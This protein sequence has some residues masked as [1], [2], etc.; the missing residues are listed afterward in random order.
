MMNRMFSVLPLCAAVLLSACGGGGDGSGDVGNQVPNTSTPTTND[1]SPS[2]KVVVDGSGGKRVV[3]KSIATGSGGPIS[4]HQWVIERAIQDDA[5]PLPAL[6]NANCIVSERSFVNNTASSTCEVIAVIPKVAI[7]TTWKLSNRVSVPSGEKSASVIVTAQPS[8]SGGNLGIQIDQSNT[9]P[10]VG[11]E[12]VVKIECTARNTGGESPVVTWSFG[13]L[14]LNGQPYSI[15]PKTSITS[16]E[17]GVVTST[18]TITA[19]TI[20]SVASMPLTCIASDPSLSK[21]VKKD[22]TLSFFPEI[23]MPFNVLGGQ[24]ISGSSGQNISLPVSIQDPTGQFNPRNVYVRWS[25]VSG[26]TPIIATGGYRYGTPLIFTAPPSLDMDN[27][28]RY[29]FQ[30]EASSIPWREGMVVP[31]SQKAQVNFLNYPDSQPLFVSIDSEQSVHTSSTV[32]LV[33]NVKADNGVK[34]TGY[35]WTFASI[36]TGSKAQILNGSQPVSSFFADVKGEYRVTLKINAIDSSGRGFTRSAGTI[37][38]ADV[39]AGKETRLD[40]NA[41]STQTVNVNVPVNLVAQEDAYGVTV[42]NRVWAF[43]SVP[44]GVSPPPF[45]NGATKNAQFI[46]KAQG[47]YVVSYT[48]TGVNNS[49]LQPITASSQVIINVTNVEGS[50][51]RF[52]VNAGNLQNVF[53]SV[54]VSLSAQED[55]LG[56]TIKTR[57]WSFVGVPSGVTPPVIVNASAK[58]S[59]F[60]PIS[61][62]VYTLS[63]TVTGEN[64][65]TLQPIT[66]SS[67]VIVNASVEPGKESRMVV[68]AGSPQSVSASS[69]VTVTAQEDIVGYTIQS[70]LWSIVSAP[71]TSVAALVNASSVSA[72]FV[73]SIPGVYVLRYTLTGTNTLTL[74][75]LPSVSETIIVV[76]SANQD[77][78]VSG[79]NPITAVIGSP[80]L[81]S[82][83]ATASNGALITSSTWSMNIKPA[84]SSAILVNSSPNQAQI[85]P[86][87]AGTYVFSFRVD[88]RT[89]YGGSIVKYAYTIMV[90][91]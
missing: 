66:A 46:P 37:I 86:D 23:S 14:M 58:N 28:N 36:P 39:E 15:N 5:I 9:T 16:S 34:I 30:A 3:V 8:L 87:V 91:N 7:D 38:Y 11:S 33:S 49:T 53:T 67:Q 54:P 24:T 56:Y 70:R 12:G 85:I 61:Q 90:A 64:T 80:Q 26:A 21:S 68:N 88:G 60:I 43:V 44:S 35:A 32:N 57:L 2:G 69:P 25:Q 27:A 18:L 72:Q 13:A 73:P 77:I 82:G 74:Q 41:G 71:P 79:G 10:S 76:S 84:G 19:P 45:V 29:V 62:G 48:A 22:F 63:Y 75:P 89:L 6:E 31:D 81:I 42:N 47:V 59:Q 1:L 78:V 55:I 83:S 17:D 65:T 51:P 20:T 52:N 4:L 50:E 40:V